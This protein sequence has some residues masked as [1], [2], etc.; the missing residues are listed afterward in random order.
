MFV[1]QVRALRKCKTSRYSVVIKFQRC[2]I[3]GVAYALRV[4]KL[5]PETG[6]SDPLSVY[7]S[8]S[9]RGNNRQQFYRVAHPRRF[10]PIFDGKYY[11]IIFHSHLEVPDSK[12]DDKMKMSS[13][14]FG[15][16]LFFFFFCSF[17]ENFI[18]QRFPSLV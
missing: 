4:V 6:N 14:K 15:C 2:L 17:F 13:S 10:E 9:Y 7:V 3:I 5:A 16:F 11:T 8:S 18:K 12:M 1:R